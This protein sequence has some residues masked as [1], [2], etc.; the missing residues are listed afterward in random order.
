MKNVPVSYKIDKN[1]RLVWST[2]WGV[3]SYDD[4]VTHKDRLLSDPDFDPSYSQIADL[5]QVTRSKLTTNEVQVF[6]QFQA[7][8]PG[9]RRALVAKDDGLF[10]L[11]RMYA[12]LRDIR[13]ESGIGVFRNVEDALDWISS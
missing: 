8:S 9:S 13:G 2:A 4:I 3:F 11:G 5:T 12:T 1:R 7:F 10:G 6:A